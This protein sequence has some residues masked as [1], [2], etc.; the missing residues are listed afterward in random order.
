MKKTFFALS[1][2]FLIPFSQAAQKTKWVTDIAECGISYMSIYCEADQYVCGYDKILNCV[3]PEDAVSAKKDMVAT[4]DI[5][6]GLTAGLVLNCYASAD[7][8]LPWRCQSDESCNSKN[9]ITK[10][11]AKGGVECGTC[12]P[13][14]NDCNG[15]AND[16]CESKD[17]KI[18]NQARIEGCV[19]KVPKVICEDGYLN[20]NGEANDGCEIKIDGPCQ[21]DGKDGQY[22]TTCKGSTPPTCNLFAQ[23]FV[24]TQNETGE[25]VVSK[26]QVDEEGSIN[27][28]EGEQ[29]MIGGVP[30]AQIALECVKNEIQMG[31]KCVVIP[32]CDFLK[33]TA[34]EFQCA[35]KPTQIEE[36]KLY[37]GDCSTSQI[38]IGGICQTVPQCDLLRFDAINGKF[39]CVL[40][41]ELLKTIE[42]V[43]VKKINLKCQKAQVLQWDGTDFQ[44]ADLPKLE[45][46]EVPKEIISS[47]IK[48]VPEVKIEK[49]SFWQ[50]IM[51]LFL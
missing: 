32:E 8:C 38:R 4:Q 29:F 44:C 33:F 18:G 50:K 37:P 40:E 15:E 23:Q 1:F 26:V 22:G 27:I 35:K 3:K 43:F 28:P 25:S 41:D 42:T 5:G 6:T 11:L 36:S 14:F 49:K 24:P 30:I 17:G 31:E 19:G 39:L 45:K 51:D 13:G 2:L 12:V 48:I 46:V 16:G 34:G 7:S 9:K 20:C 21:Q 10:C 47:K